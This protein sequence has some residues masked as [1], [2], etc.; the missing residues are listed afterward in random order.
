MSAH[1]EAVIEAAKTGKAKPYR[2]AVQEQIGDI[3]SAIL[4]AL[5]QQDVRMVAKRG[6]YV[7]EKDGLK[8]GMRV[9]R[10]NCGG[11]SI[12]GRPMRGFNKRDG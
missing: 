5:G 9:Q 11:L 1:C 4:H 2:L 6:R 12:S 10:A 3:Q 8:R 7:A